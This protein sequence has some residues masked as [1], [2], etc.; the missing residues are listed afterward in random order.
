[1]DCGC[2]VC[3]EQFTEFVENCCNFH[4]AHFQRKSDIYMI[5]KEP[6][7]ED[8][9]EVGD[10][11]DEHPWFIIRMGEDANLLLQI[12]ETLFNFLPNCDEL[13][14]IPMNDRWHLHKNKLRTFNSVEHT[15][16]LLAE[17]RIHRDTI[18]EYPTSE[19][20]QPG[21]F[22]TQCIAIHC[23]LCWD[24]YII[25]KSDD[26]SIGYYDIEWCN[27]SGMR[28]MRYII[29][30]LIISHVAY[31]PMFIKWIMEYDTDDDNLRTMERI[32]DLINNELKVH[33]E[34]N[35]MDESLHLDT[36]YKAFYKRLYGVPIQLANCT[37]PEHYHNLHERYFNDV[38]AGH[39]MAS[40][41]WMREAMDNMEE[42][43]VF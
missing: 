32:R 26:E 12:L 39:P 40:N 34:I 4:D 28:Y 22:N 1:M 16:F 25:I 19:F 31:D 6:R 20:L 35:Y 18:T 14:N 37:T 5:H 7:M 10:N 13:S 41:G 36:D 15:N 43:G 30:E 24:K 23:F 17:H 11:V 3:R 38:I 27:E 21:Y 9:K 29:L 8:F 42:M 33:L 2:H